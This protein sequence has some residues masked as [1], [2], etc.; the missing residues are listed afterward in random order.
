[1]TAKYL[2][3]LWD[4]YN[5]RT[6]FLPCIDIKNIISIPVVATLLLKIIMTVQGKLS[7]ADQL[8]AY[9]D[10]AL[11]LLHL[12]E[13]TKWSAQYWAWTEVRTSCSEC[14]SLCWFN[15]QRQ[16]TAARVPICINSDEM[17]LFIHYTADFTDYNIWWERRKFILRSWEDTRR[18]DVWKAG[19]GVMVGFGADTL[20]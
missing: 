7:G 10:D 17:N 20:F 11:V 5:N 9:L 13:Q 6:V 8:Y 16:S 3:L 2:S 18:M 4:I 15:P 12:L 1:M 19:F 14:D